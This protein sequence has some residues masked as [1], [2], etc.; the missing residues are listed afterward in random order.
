MK[1]LC[2]YCRQIY[3]ARS[4]QSPRLLREVDNETTELCRTTESPLLAKS[5][6]LRRTAE[7]ERGR[8][9][10]HRQ[11]SPLQ[12]VPFRQVPAPERRLSSDDDELGRHGRQDD[13][14]VQRQVGARRR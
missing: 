13:V 11:E 12:E 5:T 1:W 14:Q 4:T 3:E 2:D 6:Q 10:G 8:S 9:S 7:L